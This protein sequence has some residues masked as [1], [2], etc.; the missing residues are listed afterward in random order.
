[1]ILPDFNS[2]GGIVERLC[3][4]AVNPNRNILNYFPSDD[5][6]KS[7]TDNKSMM[8]TEEI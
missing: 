5:K 6:M 7:T 2:Y 3:R 1:M 4:F 8:R